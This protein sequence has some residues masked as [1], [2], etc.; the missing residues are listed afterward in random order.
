MNIKIR[1]LLKRVIITIISLSLII[2]IALNITNYSQT[3]KIK[4]SN[5]KTINQFIVQ[6]DFNLENL[7]K[8]E[9]ESSKKPNENC[10]NPY[11]DGL[12][13]KAFLFD[14]CNSII[15]FNFKGFDDPSNGTIHLWLSPKWKDKTKIKRYLFDEGKDFSHDRISIYIDEVN[16]LVFRIYDIDGSNYAVQTDVSYF[17]E[18]EWYNIIAIWSTETGKIELYVNGNLADDTIVKDIKLGPITGR[19][20]YLGQDMKQDSQAFSIMEVIAMWKKTISSDEIKKYN[21][22]LYEK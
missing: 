11:V 21:T 13:G 1:L 6:G 22:R 3:I 19:N 7:Q 16:Y 15:I 12:F 17:E 5:I 18:G 8:L 9:E 2:S 10:F 14:E 20:V 4:N